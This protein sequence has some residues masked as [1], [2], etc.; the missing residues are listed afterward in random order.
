MIGSCSSEVDNEKEMW[1]LIEFCQLGEL[2]KFLIK[3][4]KQILSDRTEDPINSKCLLYFFNVPA[5]F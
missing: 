5:T 4:K 1:L 2:K 3:N